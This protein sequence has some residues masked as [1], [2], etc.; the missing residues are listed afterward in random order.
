ML[1][2]EIII[3]NI[4]I[5]NLVLFI[6]YFT[7]SLINKFI[8]NNKS[9]LKT[10]LSIV[11]SRLIVGLFFYV[12]IFS[13]I[14]AEGETSNILI[15][16]ILLSIFYL[17]KKY[18]YAEYNTINII[19]KNLF[20]IFIGSVIFILLH[21]YLFLKNEKFPFVL[22]YYDL[23]IYSDISNCLSIFGIENRALWANVFFQETNKIIY[24][25]FFELW[26]NAVIIFFFKTLALPTYLF[27]TIPCFY[28]ILFIGILSLWEFYGKLNVYKVI[29]S[30][31]FMFF[32]GLYLL[33]YDNFSFLDFIQE[34]TYT[35][36]I[37][38]SVQGTKLILP[39]IVLIMGIISLQNKKENLFYL[40]LL[41]LPIL[42][43]SMFAP[44]IGTFL[45]IIAYKLVFNIKNKKYWYLAISISLYILIFVLFPIISN[46]N[47]PSNTEI[48]LKEK[49]VEN[50]NFI[51]YRL[52][53]Y[54][55]FKNI[56]R[57]IIMHPLPYIVLYGPTFILFA[58]IYKNNK[59]N[60]EFN[61]VEMLK[62][63][64][65]FFIVAIISSSIVCYMVDSV[66]IITNIMDVVLFSVFVVF[67]IAF[68]SNFK[69]SN[70]NNIIYNY[71]IAFSI[72]S[73]LLFNIFT[74]FIITPTYNYLG[75]NNY[76]NYNNN[77]FYNI[78]NYTLKNG[79][80]SLA[81]FEYN[82]IIDYKSE[83]KRKIL[84]N[85]DFYLYM[86][87]I[88]YTVDLSLV[89]INCKNEGWHIKPWLDKILDNAIFNLYLKN[90]NLTNIKEAQIKYILENKI[91]YLILSKNINIPSELKNYIDIIFIDEYSG[92]KFIGLKF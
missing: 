42:F 11:F 45:I 9:V 37:L 78:N 67:S 20:F 72:I 27:I 2:F 17:I 51:Y 91:R 55:Y 1:L 18:K 43:L 6:V 70:K 35:H 12:F 44:I 88:E 23:V 68:F 21:S 33:F 80:S 92:D 90:N 85:N 77:Y 83:M 48:S 39:T 31:C 61:V 65:S 89:Y 74:K 57:A 38:F 22:P 84:N 81:Y 69:K 16:P 14:K 73:I 79:K 13:L 54:Q 56:F 4:F 25:H 26:V 86:K 66:Q 7:G 28:T 49:L 53:N 76:N 19:N 50:W 58:G 46:I 40:L 5:L 24:Y 63:F 59:N 15:I 41:I 75:Y 47:I 62:L 32:E 71:V 87:N 3:K 8:L 30:F 52:L 64:L 36:S 29:L 10:N 82:D 34:R 60:F